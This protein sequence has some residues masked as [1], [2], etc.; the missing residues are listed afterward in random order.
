VSDDDRIEWARELYGGLLDAGL[1]GYESVIDVDPDRD[2]DRVPEVARRL[3][4]L[5]REHPEY[6][7]VALRIDGVPEGPVVGIS[8]RARVREHLGVAGW[9]TS[10]GAGVGSATPGGTADWGAGDRAALLGVSTQYRALLF[11]C[12]VCGQGAARA[13]HDERNTPQCTAAHGDMELV[14]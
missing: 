12:R 8:S 14:R 10:S 11:V 5:F 1:T 9:G 13:Y 7:G 6:H 4:A 3:D 2:Q